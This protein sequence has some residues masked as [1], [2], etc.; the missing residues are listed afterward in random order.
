M[1][2]SQFASGRDNNFNLIRFFAAFAVLFSHSFALVAGSGDAEPLRAST[3]MTLG[4]MAVDIFFITSGFL[5]TASL[6]T[7]QSVVEFVAA[8]VLRI[9]PALL[10][11][12]TLT[13]L[14][15]GLYFSTLSASGYLFEKETVSYFVKNVTLVFGVAYKLPGV[16]EQLPLKGAV[17]GSLWTLSYEL[18]MY[19]TLLGIW[20]ALGRLTKNRMTI[21]PKVIVLL[22]ILGLGVFFLDHFYLHSESKT[23]RLFFVFFAGAA[24]YVMKERLV[25]DS[26]IF[27]S[28]TLVVLLASFDKEA[29]FVIYY[30]AIAYLL[31]WLAYIPTGVIRKFNLIGDYSYGI[32]IYAFL[33]QQSLIALIPDVSVLG[34]LVLSSIVTLSLAFLSW[35][36]VEKRALSFKGHCV[37]MTRKTLSFVRAA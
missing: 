17:N 8:R 9:Y 4:T 33:I 21:F 5:V 32:Y 10:V 35:E 6:L 27:I 19:V 15:V 14:L 30:L 23:L 26:R 2:L 34:L 12:V 16:F 3:G 29:F 28:A 20:M 36:F 13:V 24:F 18:A 37:E 7:R 25:L 31:F 22:A 11:M 1:K